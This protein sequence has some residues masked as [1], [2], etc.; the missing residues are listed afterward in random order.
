MSELNVV[1]IYRT[2]N[3]AQQKRISDHRASV[4]LDVNGNLQTHEEEINIAGK[5]T[6][7]NKII[8]VIPKDTEKKITFKEA[9][10][11]F[12]DL[13]HM[14]VLLTNAC[15]LNCS[16][17][18]EQ[19]NKDFGRFTIDS[20]KKS[21]DWLTTVNNN[22]KKVFQFFG[23]EPLIHKK[24]I[25]DFIETYD[26][27]LESNYD[28]YRGTHISM[29]SNGLLLDEEFIKFYFGK[30]YTHMLISLDTFNSAVDHREI[31]PEQLNKIVS[32]IE[33]IIKVVDEPQRL[34][35]RATL[36]EETAPDMGEFIDRLYEKGVRSIIVHP[37][38]LDSRRGF[39]KW[40][41]K[42]WNTMREQIFRALGQYKDLYIKFSE[43]VGMKS[44]NNC[45]VGS[46]MIA[47]D[48]SG[49]FSGCY[50]FTNQKSNGADITILGNIFNDSVY[51]DRYK[52]FQN[53]YAEM[54][55]KEEQ[56]Q[57]CDYQDACYQCPAGN[58]DTGGSLF[59]PDDMCQKIVK[60]YL[61]FQKDVTKK[62]F[63]RLVD[64]RFDRLN[65]IGEKVMAAE[66]AYFSDVHF[67]IYDRKLEYYLGLD[68]PNYRVILGNWLQ[69]MNDESID[70]LDNSYEEIELDTFFKTVTNKKELIKQYPPIE[71]DYLKCFY[72]Q[73]ISTLVFD[74][75]RINEVKLSTLLA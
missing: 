20:L 75:D 22:N 31:T 72:I 60:L 18:Y 10:Y 14:N 65:K 4:S 57:T 13:V 29:C 74:T 5:G 12:R 54:F 6:K 9:D 69:H 1:K 47:I 11:L 73:C 34:V 55:A 39:I 48:A 61:D 33:Q 8:S 41:D 23:G 45:M 21:Y 64:M 2:L 62:H 59:R 67:G 19:H 35:I 46:D 15:N 49:D 26:K 63:N 32:H 56:C 28:N 25:R 51:I 53:A 17:C 38:V 50:F 52:N 24:L 44:D 66:I 42:N 71:N 7:T 27:E 30:S 68:L 37:L 16:Y 58:L 3:E 43:G 36:S 70:F 40:E